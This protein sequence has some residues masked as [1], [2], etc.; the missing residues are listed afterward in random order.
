[1]SVSDKVKITP[2]MERIIC[3]SVLSAPFVRK[4]LQKAARDLGLSFYAVR[5][6]WYKNLKAQHQPDDLRKL[7]FKPRF[8]GKV[9]VEQALNEAAN[10]DR[11]TKEA[12][13]KVAR[14]AGIHYHEALSAWGSM[15]AHD[16]VR[17]RNSECNAE[18]CAGAGICRW[19]AAEVFA[20]C[21]KKGV[22]AREIAEEC[23]ISPE[24]VEQMALAYKM[25]PKE[26]DRKYGLE[27]GYYLIAA[28]TD[29]RSPYEWMELAKD[30][31]WSLQDLKD[32]I[33]GKPV[34][35]AEYLRRENADLKKEVDSLKS[36]LASARNTPLRK[37]IEA[38]K[39]SLVEK[40]KEVADLKYEITSLKYH[41]ARQEKYILTFGH[42]LQLYEK[43]AEQEREISALR[44]LNMVY[45]ESLRKKNA[46]VFAL[47][48]HSP[49]FPSVS[50]ENT[51]QE[52]HIN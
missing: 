33:E 46:K 4:G 48:K 25:F 41:Q 5:D 6:Y 32:A 49:K 51:I 35:T 12:I 38:L 1:M 17:A 24:L 22:S 20:K 45:L 30:N 39:A 42:L 3:D 18:G 36:A 10:G 9:P 7:Y 50:T 31:G 28:N 19:R 47:Q 40:E 44:R 2:I 26:K 8:R 15:H 23:G 16:K 37:E 13:E 21:L 11:L 29:K 43:I 14:M 27:F 52:A 34:K